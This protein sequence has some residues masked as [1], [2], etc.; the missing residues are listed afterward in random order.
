V[1]TA[2]VWTTYSTDADGGVLRIAEATYQV[3]MP[4]DEGADGGVTITARIF[5]Q[6]TT[7]HCVA[8]LEAT[9]G[10][11]D[12]R[13]TLA[14]IYGATGMAPPIELTSAEVTAPLGPGAVTGGCGCTSTGG[15]ASSWP[16]TFLRSAFEGEGHSE[17]NVS[18][19]AEVSRQAVTHSEASL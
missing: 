6:S 10:T 11:D 16:S 14:S 2:P 9:D 19:R 3:P 12:A 8:A 4:A 17:P 5:H 18:S 13:T 7:R 15:K 1:D